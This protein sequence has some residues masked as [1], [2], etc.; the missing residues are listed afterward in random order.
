M[1]SIYLVVSA[2]PVSGVESTIRL[3][4]AEAT[5]AARS[6]AESIMGGRPFQIVLMDGQRVLMS[7]SSTGSSLVTPMP[8]ASIS[9]AI[10]AMTI[11]QLIEEGRLELES[12]LRDVLPPEIMN[13]A[14]GDVTIAQLLSHT[15][16]F[17]AD[18]ER[19]F[20][21]SYFSCVEA[22]SLTVNRRTRP[23]S[24]S[25]AYSN[26]NFCAL[27]LVIVSITGLSFEEATYRYVFRPLGIA[28]QSL[29]SEYANLLGAGGWR[30]S[31]LDTA[32]IVSALDPQAAIS[33]LT[34]ASRQKMIERTTYEYGLG[35]W[36]FGNDAFGHSGT[37]NRARNIAI[38]LP[39]QRVVVILTQASY[40]ESGLELESVAQRIDRAYAAT[41]AASTCETAGLDVFL[42]DV[43]EVI[44][45]SFF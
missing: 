19:W 9:K 25:Y 40:P 15:S 24:N 23:V 27:S 44:R 37:L 10:T 16:G 21:S 34:V 1:A 43:R 45:Q 18:R 26:T 13:D 2:G 38:R 11:M 41:C 42:G 22:F 32:R 5:V 36:I 31:A 8:L 14:W 28:R 33:P 17:E 4:Y 6:E 7:A 20:N 3:R 12:T 30:L 35:V 29:D 39:S